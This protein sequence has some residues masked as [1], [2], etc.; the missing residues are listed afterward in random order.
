MD[1]FYSWCIRYQGAIS[2]T[3]ALFLFAALAMIAPSTAQGADEFGGRLEEHELKFDAKCIRGADSADLW[4]TAL[5]QDWDEVPVW[6]GNN[7][8]GRIIITRNSH[9]PTWSFLIETPDG[10]C[11]VSS[12]DSHFLNDVDGAA[13]KFPSKSDSGSDDGR[14]M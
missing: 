3:L 2:F 9:N 6:I 7:D 14:S 12:G 4:V 5:M 10:T 13:Q 11:M 8:G 1:K